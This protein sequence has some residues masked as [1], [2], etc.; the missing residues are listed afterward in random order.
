MR[1]VRLL[2]SVFLL[3]TILTSFDLSAQ[4]PPLSPESLVKGVGCVEPGIEGGCLVI[5]DTTS[6]VTY[7][8]F[9]KGTAPRVDTA[10]SFEGVPNNNPNI[11]NSNQP[12]QITK[13]TPLKLHCPLPETTSSSAG[14][15]NGS[16]PQCSDWSSWYNVQPGGPKSLHV[17]GT[18]SIRVGSKVSLTPNV[19]PGFNPTIYLLTLTVIS[20]QGSHA[21]NALIQQTVSYSESTDMRYDSVQIDPLGVV[22]PVK[23]IQ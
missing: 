23:V 21:S 1:T 22:I 5:R 16:L 19:P 4:S 17:K 11:C 20:P 6:K 9:F 2:T 10:I 15:D 14:G 18:C 12:L 13:W 7:D 8:V 3:S